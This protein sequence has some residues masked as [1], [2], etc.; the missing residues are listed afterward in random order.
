MVILFAEDNP[1]KTI[2]T[3]ESFGTFKLD[4]CIQLFGNSTLVIVTETGQPGTWFQVRKEK[5]F[6][7]AYDI[8]TLFGSES[9]ELELTARVIAETVYKYSD[10]QL[11]LS[12]NLSHHSKPTLTAICNQVKTALTSLLLPPTSA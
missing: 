2:T 3:T 1:I 8:T 9:P 5:L 10:Q 12:I 11:I 4:F 7:D 6:Q